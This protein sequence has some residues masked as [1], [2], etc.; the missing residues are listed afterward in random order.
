[1]KQK[2]LSAMRLFEVLIF[3]FVYAALTV[4]WFGF[5]AREMM[6]SV[7]TGTV[8]VGFAGSVL[9]LICTACI[10]VYVI[11][12]WHPTKSTEKQS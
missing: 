4:A 8:L 1:M 5:A 3:V 10:V 7:H 9:W 6:S 12:K 11:N 2:R